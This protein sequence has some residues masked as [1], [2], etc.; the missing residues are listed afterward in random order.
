MVAIYKSGYGYIDEANGMTISGLE[1]EYR[2]AI[3]E[4]I[5]T[6]YYVWR[7]SD[8]REPELTALVREIGSGPTIGFYEEPEELNEFV[9]RDL[10]ALITARFLAATT[11]R[12][13]L[14]EDSREILAKAATRAGVIV[15]RDALKAEV[16]HALTESQVVCLHGTAGIG[17]TTLAAQ[18]SDD[19]GSVFLRA[20]GLTPKEIFA[21]CA[22]LVR[23][24]DR[25]HVPSYSTLEGARLALASA[26]AEASMI[27]LVVDE[28][29]FV[30]ELL[31]AL[32][33]GGGFTE[34]KKFVF[35][36]HKASTEYRNVEIPSLT[37]EEMTFIL[38]NSAAG[39]QVRVSELTGGIPLDVQRALSTAARQKIGPLPV[40][41]RGS[42]GEVLRYLALAAS[43]LTADDLLRLRADDRYSIDE[44]TDDV[45]QLGSIIEDRPRGYRLIHAPTIVAVVKELK[46]QPQRHRFFANRLIR[47]AENNGTIRLAYSLAKSLDDGSERKFI[48]GAVREAA[49]LGDW[50]LGVQLVEEMLARAL[51]AD[52]KAE[53]LHHM[54]S[55]VYPLELMGDTGRAGA[56][57][58]K[59]REL[60]TVL[61]EDALLLWEEFDVSAKARRALS[62]ADV[63]ELRNIRSRYAEKGRGW[64]EA[65]I[66]LEL[67][68]IYLASKKFGEAAQVLRPT[69]QTFRDLGDDYGIDLAERNLAS[70]LSAIEGAEEEAERLIAVISARGESGT[71]ERRQRAWLCNILTRRMRTSGRFDDAEKLANEAI[72]LAE[73]LGDESLRAINIVNL[74]NIYRSRSEPEKAIATYEA[75]AVAANKC[76]RRDIE[77]DASR[78][79]AGVLNDFEDVE[80][81]G[82]RRRRAALYAQA[83]IGLLRGS[84]YE[85]ALARAYWEL[86][87]A[88][89]AQGKTV[90]AIDAAFESASAFRRDLDLESFGRALNYASGMALPDHPE[91]YVRG[92]A[93]VLGIDSNVPADG[94]L[95][96]FLRLVVPILANSPKAAFISLLGLHLGTAWS[97][98]SP[99]MQRGFAQAG[100]EKLRHFAHTPEANSEPW[101]VLYAGIA[102]A[103]LMKHTEQPYLHHRLA[104]SVVRNVQDIYFREDGEGSRVWTVV[105]N[106]DRRV[107]LTVLPLDN[108]A[109]SNLACFVL[110]VFV[111]A[112]DKELY[113]E[114]VG[115]GSDVDELLVEVASIDEMPSEVR[116][117][118]GK[119]VALDQVLSTQACVATRPS[120]F[121]RTSPTFV[122]L[123][124]DFIEQVSVLREG[125]HALEL[126]LALTLTEL[127]FQLLRGQVEMEAIR[128]KIVS[129]VRRARP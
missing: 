94:L 23:D 48:N 74:G 80:G 72:A 58:A 33:A 120:G 18:L 40:D 10:T 69:L 55:L 129:L 64:D 119:A 97:G 108:S 42:A 115:S 49:Q 25:D 1:D 100:V 96:S 105:L 79:I 104:D 116:E 51:D 2:F 4:S 63:Q 47:L 118:A 88:Q 90:D 103:S 57:L 86:A 17:K 67:S 30:A 98:L 52:S 112:F 8:K 28:C 92:L 85:E 123:A 126:L 59:A 65:R 122:F 84:V 62:A 70:A 34:G 78:L 127:A 93:S 39:S 113:T 15:Q 109:A 19:S 41:V 3:Q 21:T 87:E 73:Q 36:S 50:P 61:G 37:T 35:T 16:R 111:K 121:T 24:N 5:D 128:P 29:D 14:E 54:L 110:A 82:D 12:G 102:L 124:S 106:L 22:V 46:Q 77:G 31:T 44:L 91:A 60:A 68:A 76:G 20:S 75:A 81:I 7:H 95:A 125:G 117:L 6:L 45:E 114:L 53:A 32:S 38:G 66:G 99:V 71:D 9:K 107:T 27:T 101:R 11:Q 13:A 83:A 43:H 26:W 89:E 56:M